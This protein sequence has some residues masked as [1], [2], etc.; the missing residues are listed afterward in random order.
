MGPRGFL[1]ARLD[2]GFIGAVAIAF[3]SHLP[4]ILRPEHFWTL[5]MQGVGSHINHKS[6]AESLRS[7][8]VKHKGKMVLT[9]HRDSFQ[10]GK[11]G[12]DWAGVVAEFNQQISSHVVPDAAKAMEMSFSTTT[13]DEKTCG[14]VAVMSAMQ[15]FF[16]HKMCTMCGFPSITLE[17]SL[18]DWQLLRRKAEE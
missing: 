7:K 13:A 5:I 9:V 18:A 14:A 12:N 11:A 4:L 17:G 6:N 10:L 15:K 8:F 1:K 3:D 16:T 2:N